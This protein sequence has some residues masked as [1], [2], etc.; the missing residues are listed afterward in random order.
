MLTFILKKKWYEKIKSG[1]KTME[2]R[3]FTEYWKTRVYNALISLA[4]NEKPICILRLGYTKQYMT[5]KISEIDIVNGKETDLHIDSQVYAF[6]LSE[7]KE[8]NYMPITKE[9]C[10]KMLIHKQQSML[11]PEIRLL[12]VGEDS[13]HTICSLCAKKG[14]KN[15]KHPQHRVNDIPDLQPPEETEE[16][17]YNNCTVC[18][19][20]CEFSR[21]K[22]NG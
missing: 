16:Y 9:V 14:I 17:C 19:N 8:C 22:E 13:K 3:E 2:Y 15:S 18:T 11:L 10:R 20:E 21:K 4:P 5:A 6:H 12:L 1:E 7:I